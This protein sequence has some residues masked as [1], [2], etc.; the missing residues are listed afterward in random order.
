M[1]VRQQ[2]G[3]NQLDRLRKQYCAL[4]TVKE[5]AEVLRYPS[6]DAVRVAYRRGRLPVRLYKFERRKGY[7]A[8]IEEV[9]KCLDEMETWC[10]MGAAVKDQA[11]T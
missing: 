7:Y 1:N 9:A 5:L 11:D 6:A 10:P 4:M 2:H 8:K 3:G